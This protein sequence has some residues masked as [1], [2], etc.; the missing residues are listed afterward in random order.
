MIR[1][2]GGLIASQIISPADIEADATRGDECGDGEKA[3]VLS[4]LEKV[5]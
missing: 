1:S 3:S 2:R 4:L 5:I